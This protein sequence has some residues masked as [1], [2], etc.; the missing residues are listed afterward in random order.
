MLRLYPMIAVLK[1]VIAPLFIFAQTNIS[2]IINSYH[3]VIEVIPSKSCVR[4]DNTTGLSSNNTVMLVQM[5]GA[6]VSTSNNSSFGSVISM[7]NAGNYEINSVCSIRDDSVFLFRQILQSYTVSAKV[8]LVKIPEY[9][10]AIVV[11]SLKA[12]PWDSA[13]GK[14]GVLGLIVSDDIILSAPIWASNAGYKGG[15]NIISG[16]SCSNFFAANDYYYDATS[17]NPQED[18]KSV[19]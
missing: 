7:N 1:M 10:S 13:T 8:Q 11:D 12:L 2:G 17:L 3:K 15:T 5:K 6:T 19:V 18:R 4:V 16:S 14:G 9:S